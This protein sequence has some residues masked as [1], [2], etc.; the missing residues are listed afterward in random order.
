MKVFFSAWKSFR[1][2]KLRFLAATGILRKKKIS[3]EYL[4]IWWL[5]LRAQRL[6]FAK[7]FD[8]CAIFASARSSRRILRF[9]SSERC[10]LYIGEDVN[11]RVNVSFGYLLSKSARWREFLFSRRRRL[12][13]TLTP[14][15]PNFAWCWYFLSVWDI[16]KDVQASM[17]DSVYL[18]GASAI[19]RFKM[20]RESKVQ[21]IREFF[22][23]SSKYSTHWNISRAPLLS[24]WICNICRCLGTQTLLFVN[25]YS[26]SLAGRVA[27]HISLVVA[28]CLYSAE[29]KFTSPDIG[30]KCDLKDRKSRI[31]K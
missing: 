26:L 23:P 7:R 29:Y 25:I 24:T 2:G 31:K 10:I 8:F 14:D 17:W 9:C 12:N 28:F 4:F 11:V 6:S 21:R 27:R 22:S 16:K 19:A 3:E 30:E 1:S 5:A 18:T 20:D 15:D 13:F